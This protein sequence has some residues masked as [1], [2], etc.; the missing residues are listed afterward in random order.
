MLGKPSSPIYLVS[1]ILKW[2]THL[3]MRM[4]HFALLASITACFVT[5]GSGNIFGADPG[6]SPKGAVPPPSMDARLPLNDNTAPPF[7]VV[8]REGQAGCKRGLYDSYG[9]WLNR[10]VTWA[11]DFMPIDDWSQ[12]EGRSWLLGT[13]SEWV[14][15]QPGRRFVLSLPILPGPWDLRGPKTGPRGGNPVS[16]QE[17]AKGTYNIHF[18]HLAENLVNSG[19]GDT[20]IRV[21]WEFNGNWYAWRIDT[22]EKAEAFA[23]YFRQIVTTMRA[24]PGGNNLKFI[25][26][27]TIGVFWPKGTSPEKAWP[28]DDF[29]D[30]VGLDVY[31]ASWAKDTYPI[32]KDASADEALARRKRVWDS[33]LNNESYLGL[34]YW[35]KFN[36][37]HKKP[38]VI[39]EWGVCQLKGKDNH[40]GGDNVFFVEQMFNFIYNPINNVYFD[41]YFDISARDGD[42][43]LFPNEN[44]TQFPLASARYKELF[45]LPQTVTETQGQASRLSPA[46]N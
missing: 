37:K 29:V 13:W 10:N 30:Y 11:E 41:C 42:H 46:R 31:D 14:K 1:D 33:V 2:R 39:C 4:T 16:L 12:I 8:Y 6:P 38:L 40:G 44:G 3:N 19:L 28:G 5:L 20:L 36:A 32:P 34:P 27:P 23:G 22:P 7:K 18:Q 43:R 21:G 26:N 45:T 24:V 17:G 25:W 15:K 35:V 9:T